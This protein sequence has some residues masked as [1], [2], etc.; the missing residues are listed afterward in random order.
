[1]TNHRTKEQRFGCIR[2]GCG[3]VGTAVAYD[4]G[5][6]V[7]PL[8]CGS[9][10]VPCGACGAVGMHGEG[11]TADPANQLHWHHDADTRRLAEKLYIAL[12][13]M[14]GA[15]ERRIRSLCE[16]PE[17]LARKPWECME[18]RVAESACQS[19]NRRSV[20]TINEHLKRKIASDPDDDPSAGGGPP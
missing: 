15:Y 16:T 18:W 9:L 10:A 12:R 8:C 11:C 6:Q 4:Q 1:M 13:A 2:Q 14:M 19:F 3:W 5:V 20:A 17:E 7:C